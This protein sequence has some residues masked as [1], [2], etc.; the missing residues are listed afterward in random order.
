VGVGV[1]GAGME[2]ADEVGV[3]FAENLQ[4][5]QVR[6]ILRAQQAPSPPAPNQPAPL[7]GCMPMPMHI[8]R[9]FPFVWLAGWLAGWLTVPPLSVCMPMPMHILPPLSLRL[10]GWL[11]GW[12]AGR[13]SGCVGVWLCL[14]LSVALSRSLLTADTRHRRTSRHR[15][16]R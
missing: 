10:A 11:A 6:A 8:L 16:T 9:P 1:G 4:L 12:L 15:S 2:E 3:L 7:S 14:A 5:L 13:V